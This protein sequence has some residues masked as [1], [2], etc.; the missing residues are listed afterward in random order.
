MV[1]RMVS[2]SVILVWLFPCLGLNLNW[3]LNWIIFL[4]CEQQGERAGFELRGSVHFDADGILDHT[5]P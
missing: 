2:W 5:G 1:V 4:E 3:V